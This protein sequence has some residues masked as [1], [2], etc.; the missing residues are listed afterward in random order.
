MGSPYNYPQQLGQSTQ[1]YR[2]DLFWL[3][4]SHSIKGGVDYLHT[5]YSG[6]FGQN[7]RGT[8]L[9][10]SSGVSALNLASIFPTW[11][12]PST[13]NLAALSQYATSY[14]QGFGNY[15]YSVSTNAVGDGSRTTGRLARG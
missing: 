11:N 6:N 15:L 10:F 4:G 5:P 8:V 9:S 7:V 12:D 2:D 14:T 1:Q 13:W 3:K